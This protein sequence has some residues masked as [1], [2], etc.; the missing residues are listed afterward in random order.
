MQLRESSGPLEYHHTNGIR[1][2]TLTADIDIDVTSVNE[3]KNKMNDCIAK[4]IIDREDTRIEF[5]GEAREA[6]KIFGGFLVSG[7]VALV[8]IYVVVALLLNS[9]AQPLIIMSAIPFAIVGVIYAFYFL[10]M[11]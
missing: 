10:G 2:D 5:A 1:T 6:K 3:V 7:I 9:L 11:S 8:S 4:N